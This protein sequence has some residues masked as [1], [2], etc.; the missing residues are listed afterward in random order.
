M[1]LKLIIF[2]IASLLSI[3]SADAKLCY[4]KDDFGLT[5]TF[6]VP[7][8]PNKDSTSGDVMLLD[9]RGKKTRAPWIDTGLT[10]LGIAVDR[11]NPQ[12][13]RSI[14]KVYVDGGWGPW[15]GD[16][17]D[18]DNCEVEPCVFGRDTPCL[19]G[20]VR[21]KIDRNKLPCLI[22]Q[23]ED[24]T[25]G[26]PSLVGLGLYGLIALEDAEGD[27]ADPNDGA[28]AAALPP[29]LFR[30][31]HLY[32]TKPGADN[33]RF[34]ELD[35]TKTCEVNNNC[36]DDVN[37]ANKGVIKKGRLFFQI[38]DTD[39]LNNEG[40]YNVT[41]VSGV[42]KQKGFIE[43]TINY[44]QASLGVVV[45]NLFIAITEDLNFISI[46]HS[47][48]LL[49][50]AMSG[51]LFM[52]GMIKTH[53]S[54]L[55]VRIVKIGIVATVI[56]EES[57]EFFNTFLFPFFTQGAQEIASMIVRAAFFYGNDPNS[58]IYFVPD[59]ANSLTI[60]DY[61][62]EVIA[63]QAVHAKILSLLFFDWRLFFIPIIYFCFYF[64]IIAII[65]SISLYIVSMMLLAVLIVIAPIFIVMILYQITSDL[66]NQWLKLMT[67]S[68]MQIIVV[69]ATLALFMS[70]FNRQIYDLLY[71][72]V[73]WDI[74][75]S[76]SFGALGTLNIWF[77]KPDF[78][79]DVQES[80]T[81]LNVFSLLIVCMLFDAFMQQVPQ[82]IDALANSALQ[83]ISGLYQG[84]SQK[85]F[86]QGG[87]YDKAAFIPNAIRGGIS[88][89]KEDKESMNRADGKIRAAVNAYDN[90]IQSKVDGI[91]QFASGNSSINK[92]KK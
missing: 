86:E 14:V 34:Y 16:L 24:K 41:V 18:I 6:A 56:S 82:L 52:M 72:K 63:A 21:L 8:N 33:R 28:F 51:L 17:N 12:F 69:S 58:P 68:A 55:I 64:L 36:I 11:E 19:S 84:A 35:L 3:S 90:Y 50:V 76:F 81:A 23:N 92:Y 66:F 73:C 87:L 65:R 62:I 32:Q 1:R 26:S 4:N 85:M 7:A 31:F 89:G 44:F 77:W 37:S 54:E 53:H 13:A 29:G 27:F 79:N 46:V 2:V 9:V 43:N 59:A 60:F 10:T 22:G 5:G 74:A 78:A 42:Y 91:A 30:T 40:K 25:K 67:S 61:M 75:L 45:K 38:Q 15:G 83:P 71:Y 70:L 80:I 39:Y 88:R 49:Y 48:L 20:G 47:M 57:W